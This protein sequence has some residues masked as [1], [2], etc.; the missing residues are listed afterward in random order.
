MSAERE[1]LCVL[2]RQRFT[3]EHRERAEAICAGTAIDWRAFVRAAA[4]GGVAPI[5]GANLAACDAATTR[6]PEA[7]SERFQQALFENVALKIERRREFLEQLVQLNARGYD[8]L[9]LKSAGLEATGVY[10]QPWVTAARDVDVVLR[11]RAPDRS[12]VE[13]RVFRESLRERG[14]ENESD[15]DAARH[16]DVSLSGIL[17]VPFDDIWS[18]AR[19][20][21]LDGDPAAVAYVMCPEDQLLTLCL[22]SSRK[23]YFRLKGLF[24]IAETAAHHPDLDW[25]LLARRIL[26]C[27]AEAIVYTAFRAVD[28]TVGLP[29]GARRF[30]RSLVGPMR[31]A[32]LLP[33]V[34]IASRSRSRIV[35]AALQYASFTGRQRWRDLRLT[36]S[37]RLP[38]A[39]AAERAQSRLPG[40]EAAAL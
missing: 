12:V 7:V 30:Y 17:T 19:R 36:L 26:A 8:A 33:L 23:R 27:D 13:D 14:V 4:A 32:V 31:A 40:E 11:D 35:P 34:R 5:A 22:N 28:V 39:T 3:A 1:L 18:A 2:L 16:H 24:D 15:R 37:N 29:A 25:A 21:E 10:E 38:R 20:I 6:V 9:L